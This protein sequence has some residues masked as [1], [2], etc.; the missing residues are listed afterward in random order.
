M[1]KRKNSIV[2]NAFAGPGA[3][4]TTL[5]ALLFA[6]MKQRRMSVGFAPEY[7]QD[8]VYREEPLTNQVEVTL[9]QYCRINTLYGKVDY[10][11]T[12]SPILLAIPYLWMQDDSRFNQQQ[13]FLWKSSFESFI[14]SSFIKFINYNILV[15]RGNRHYITDGRLQTQL[16]AEEIDRDMKF[17]LTENQIDFVEETDETNIDELIDRIVS[18][19]EEAYAK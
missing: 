9:H 12:D 19:K 15:N 18:F 1:K 6:R 4:K 5:S 8:K 17:L 14:K 11:I 13:Y 2:I 16:E 10:V 3:G 7:A